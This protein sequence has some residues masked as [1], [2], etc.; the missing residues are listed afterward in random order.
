MFDCGD[1]HGP[2]RDH[3]PG[4]LKRESIPV[5]ATTVPFAEKRRS[6]GLDL[7]SRL[8][9]SPPFQMIVAR[10]T[11]GCSMRVEKGIRVGLCGY[12]PQSITRTF[13]QCILA[14]RRISSLSRSLSVPPTAGFIGRLRKPSNEE[15]WPLAPELSGELCTIRKWCLWCDIARCLPCFERST[16]VACL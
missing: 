13:T 7:S 2:E 12:C 11:V 10:M 5:V 3:A 16:A 9:G 8:R 6:G 14:Y 15:Q 4:F 1:S